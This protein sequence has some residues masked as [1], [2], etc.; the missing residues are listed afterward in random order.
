MYNEVNS[1]IL[2]DTN[3]TFPFNFV[4]AQHNKTNRILLCHFLMS[5]QTM[6]YY[7]CKKKSF[8]FQKYEFQSASTYF[9]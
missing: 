9:C 4:I 6:H 1:V 3:I 8:V 5:L 2:A 7:L